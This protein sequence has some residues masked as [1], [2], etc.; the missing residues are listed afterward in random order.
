MKVKELKEDLK[1]LNLPSTSLKKVLVE[2]LQHALAENGKN[3]GIIDGEG[4][5]KEMNGPIIVEKKDVLFI[6]PILI[7]QTLITLLLT[8]LFALF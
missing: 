7:T 6:F 1:K 5:N 3:V 2:H 8:V 4:N